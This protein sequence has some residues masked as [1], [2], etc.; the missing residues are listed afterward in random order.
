MAR[1]RFA[2][3]QDGGSDGPR[4]TQKTLRAG[5]GGLG[6]TREDLIQTRVNSAR[7]V[8]TR[9]GVGWTRLLS[10]RPGRVSDGL[11]S[12]RGDRA[13]I[14]ADS[15]RLAG[16]RFRSRAHSAPIGPE[17][18]DLRSPRN[19]LSRLRSGVRGEE[20]VARSGACAASGMC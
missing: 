4:L 15:A 2:V 1:H 10:W 5:S 11:G 8:E 16:I 12:S 3:P 14:R 20:W 18:S 17:P 19:H 7:L 6:S 9:P 13:G